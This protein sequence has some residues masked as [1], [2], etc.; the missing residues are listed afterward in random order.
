M[1]KLRLSRFARSRKR[2]ELLR[3]HRKSWLVR[4]V[5]RKFRRGS[6][7]LMAPVGESLLASLCAARRDLR[8][9]DDGSREVTFRPRRYCE[10]ENIK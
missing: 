10:N 6:D 3:R 8:S 7:L 4:R 9:K 1:K 5:N 2:S